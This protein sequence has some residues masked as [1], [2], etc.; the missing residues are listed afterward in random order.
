V[1]NDQPKHEWTVIGPDGG[2]YW[3]ISSMG[4]DGPA[5]FIANGDWRPVR[6]RFGEFVP[7]ET[8][9][10]FLM[11]QVTPPPPAGSYVAHRIVTPGP[12]ER[13]E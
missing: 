4:P 3:G 10:D 2:T 13:V 5:D 9:D 8:G 1:S 6:N 12:W 11:E 7:N